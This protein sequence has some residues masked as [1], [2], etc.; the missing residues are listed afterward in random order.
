[1][2]QLAAPWSAQSFFGSVPAVTAAHVPRLLGTLQAWHAPQLALPQQRPSTQWPVPHWS[3]AAQALPCAI[4]A[5]Q[6]PPTPVQKK[7]PAQSPSPLHVVWQAS[8]PSHL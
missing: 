6:L 4:F 1:V 5:A 2:P 8:T 3:S 7:P